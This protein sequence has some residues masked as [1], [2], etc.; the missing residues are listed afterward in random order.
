MVR[1]R[2]SSGGTDGNLDERSAS[3]AVDIHCAH[4]R[5]V[6]EPQPGQGPALPD[7]TMT[8]PTLDVHPLIEGLVTPI[9][10]AFLSETKWLVIEKMTG[11]V[12][13][14]EDGSSRHGARPR[15][16]QRLRARPARH[17]RSPRLR[18]NGFVYLFWS[19][20]AA[21]PPA[22]EPFRRPPTTCP[23]QPDLGRRLERHAGRAAARQPGGP[24][25]L[26]RRDR[27]LRSTRT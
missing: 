16:Q 26:G 25:R 24:V 11:E 15:R 17:R 10:L 20:M 27:H 5:V 23:R 9:G 4:R 14:V 8:V 21:A 3:R 19:C 6:R 7:P 18:A 12:R 22:S 13:V 1:H 2:D